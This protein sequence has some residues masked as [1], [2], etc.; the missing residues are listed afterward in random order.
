MNSRRKF[1]R[2]AGLAS[3][4]APQLI[5]ARALGRGGSTPP[6]DRISMACIGLGWMGHDGHLTEFLKLKDVRIVAVCDLDESHLTR[7]KAMVDTEYGDQGCAPYHAFEEVLMR[8]DVDAVSIAVPDHWHGIVAT[9]AARAKKDIYCEK[10]L[11]HNFREG[12]A[13][14][15]LADRQLAAV[16]GEFP[17]RLRAGAQWPHWQDQRHRSRFAFGLL[18]GE[19]QVEARNQRPS[20]DSAL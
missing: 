11:A 19:G 16:G 17:A 3:V 15:H 5:P 20:A 8:R 14:P 1:L 9:Q 2:N 6:S 18:R 12:L 10:P 13:M 4:T 7:G